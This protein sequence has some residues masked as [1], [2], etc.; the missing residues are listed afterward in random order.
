MGF[1][2][3]VI[4]DRIW[5][6]VGRVISSH[7]FR[8]KQK[9]ANPKLSLSATKSRA[10]G[11]EDLLMIILWLSCRCEGCQEATQECRISEDFQEGLH[12]KELCLCTCEGSKSFPLYI[13]HI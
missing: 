8:R 1:R 9:V 4:D 2:D 10:P 3:G 7:P 13:E 6:V 11:L 5:C 12:S